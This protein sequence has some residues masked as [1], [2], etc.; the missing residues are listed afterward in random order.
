MIGPL[1]PT[2][3]SHGSYFLF[4]IQTQGLASSQGIGSLADEIKRWMV[5]NTQGMDTN[6]F[7][8]IDIK[9]ASSAE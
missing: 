4:M 2:V 3:L 6:K 8:L 1:T 7:R 9:Y 5:S